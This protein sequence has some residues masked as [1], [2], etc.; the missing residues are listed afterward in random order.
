MS[1]PRITEIGLG[2]LF[3]DLGFRDT[4]GLV[5]S[6]FLPLE[7]G[8]AVLE[9]GPSTCHE[10]LRRA[11]S[12]AG[13][14]PN[15]VKQ[16]FVTHIHLDH[17]GGLGAIAGSLPK[18]ELYVHREGAAHM[19]DPT[20]LIASARRAWGPAADP[21][22]GP[23]VPVP[24]ERLHGLSGGERFPLRGGGLEVLAT[25]GHARHHLAFLDTA[26]GGLMTGDAAGVRLSG[27]WRPRPAVPPPD[28]DLE[29][30]FDSLE[31]MKA[32]RPR[33]IFFSHFGESPDGPA[34]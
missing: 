10:H 2:R 5:A 22:W 13:I 31:R 18:A 16:V 3:A 24:A 29:L 15:E 11:L 30:L 21:L 34:D 23:I 25:P 7:D 26:T 12:A 6:Y 9:T 20:R 1:E 32:A 4:E 27:G 17:A 19:I 8:W 33:R 14:E 28:T